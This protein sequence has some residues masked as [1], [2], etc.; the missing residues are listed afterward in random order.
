MGVLGLGA[1]VIAQLDVLRVLG[2]W[3]PMRTIINY[4]I[5]YYEDLSMNHMEKRNE[6]TLDQSFVEIC[7]W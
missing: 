1:V 7:S 5:N 2:I 6:E 4:A 3:E